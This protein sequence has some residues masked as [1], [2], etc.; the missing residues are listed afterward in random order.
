MYFRRGRVTKQAHVDIP[1][2]TVEE[3]FGRQ[4][5]FGRVSHLYRSAPPVGW[6]RIEGDLRPEA[7]HVRELAGLG[8]GDYLS[9]RVAFLENGEVRLHMARLAGD[10]AMPY[11]FRNADADEILFVHRG[12]G[13]LESDFGPLDYETGDYLV[14]PRG[15]VHRLLP[16]GPTELLVIESFS[17]VGLPERGLLGKHALFDPD[18][19]KVPEPAPPTHDRAPGREWELKIQR[20]GRLTSVFYPFHPINTVGWKGDLTV[21]QLN[22]RD[23]R[24]IM[25][26][27]Y[28]LPPSA[29]A[30]FVGRGFVVCTF[31]PRGLETGDPGALKVPFYHSN[32]DYDE[33]LFYH[34]GSFFSRQGIGAGMVTF[35]PQGLHH[36]PQPGAVEAA[37]D[38]TRTDEI[39]VMVD[40]ERP[41]ELTR[42]AREVANPDYWAS[43]MPPEAANPVGLQGI[44]FVEYASPDPGALDV[45]FRDL[46]FSRLS[47][48]ESRPVVHY[49]QGGIHFL[50]NR[51]PDS[52]ASRFAAAHGPSICA[53]GWR[54]R[55][56]EEALEAAVAR[57]A[58]PF[59]GQG[60]LDGVPAIYG[61][62]DSLIYF[63][64]EGTSRDWTGQ[65]VPLDEPVHVEDKG[66]TLIDHLTNNVERG[67]MARWAAFYKEVFGFTEV[68]YFDIRGE[69]TGLTSYALR[70]PDGSFC[71]PINEG[72][73]DKSQI[74]EYLREYRG[75]GIQHIALLSDD[76]LGSLDRLEGCGIETLDIEDAYYETVFE[77]V[78]GVTEDRGHIQRH[79]VLVDGDE[80]GYLL[81]IF[82]KNVIGPIFFE[83]IQ[84]KNHQSFGEGNFGAL[85]RS[86][87]RDQERRGVL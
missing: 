47:R 57:G 84:R 31:L 33:V 77:R 19:I 49:Q 65:L 45:L 71:I 64:E 52:F 79:R 12:A 6:S 43:W 17:E 69:E 72:S 35:H 66:F 5:F 81:Q 56:A 46:G 14:I 8:A 40:T 54:V 85:F 3:E 73:E 25:S 36:G 39:A 86:I 59:E 26:E 22:V 78:A 44:A 83:M 63:V 16:T 87:E 82:T 62:G 58:R 34:Q 28:H 70:S 29:H 15:T 53:L 74:E 80:G 75:P 38:K 60:A 55:D 21:W 18:V 10:D 67:T 61:I 13:R 7:L 32:I 30:T 68:R 4:G 51:E 50:V 9:G 27:R 11:L 1:E 23:I 42:A 37:R 2:G 48:H 41:L 24:P 76:L 20:Q